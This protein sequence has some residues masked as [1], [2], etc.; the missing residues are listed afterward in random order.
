MTPWCK[1]VKLRD[2]HPTHFIFNLTIMHTLSFFRSAALV[3]VSSIVAPSAF[4]ATLPPTPAPPTIEARSY[5]LMDATDRAV[6]AELNADERLPPASTTKIMTSFLVEQEL[7]A[8]KIKS[9]DLVT[10]S[11]NAWRQGGSRMFVQEGTQVAVIDLLKGIIIQSGNDASVAMAEHMAG[12]EAAFADLMN[13]KAKELGMTNS[14]FL[15]ST[16]L[17]DPNHYSTARDLAILSQALVTQSASYYPLNKVRQ[18]TFNNIVQHNR[19]L[20]LYRDPTVD[21]IKTGFT[22]AAGYCLVASALRNGTR[23]IAVVMGASSPGKRADAAQALL[24]YGFRFFETRTIYT[25]G[26]ELQKLPMWFGEQDIIAVGV[27]QSVVMTIPRGQEKLI[28]TQVVANKDIRGPIK[29]GQV[30][31]KI[32]VSFNGTVRN[33]IPLVALTDVKKAGFFKGVW[34]HIYLFFLGLFNK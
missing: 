23:L 22:D 16:G 29:K 13:F 27:N 19:N 5:I 15:N 8:G 11:V 7:K 28:T 12:S 21:G 10:I 26:Q 34:Q 33:H 25:A 20:L 18:F 24:N 1:P 31:G 3:L 2:F 4:S 6:L 14:N 32:T 9:T 30:L 17:P